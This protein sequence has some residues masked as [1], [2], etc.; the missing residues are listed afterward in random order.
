MHLEI[1]HPV[2]L[3]IIMLY[4]QNHSHLTYLSLVPLICVSESAQHW[5]RWW[6]VAYSVPSHYLNQWWVIV[7]WTLRNRTS[8]SEILIKTQDFL[9]TKM[10][11]K[12]S[13]AKWQ[14]FFQGVGGGGGV[15]WVNNKIYK[16]NRSMTG[17]GHL[18]VFDLADWTCGIPP[19]SN[20]ETIITI[21]IKIE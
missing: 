9:F 4:H 15:G 3:S 16:L 17:S 6:L 7:N 8:F 19:N 18:L 21:N 10:H 5:F 2:Q 12:I 11:L 1:C 14:P 13:S 20:C